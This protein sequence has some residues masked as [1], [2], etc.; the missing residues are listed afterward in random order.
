[1]AQFGHIVAQKQAVLTEKSKSSQKLEAHL[2]THTYLYVKDI[3]AYVEA[4]F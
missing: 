3:V 4:A 1:M 2:Q